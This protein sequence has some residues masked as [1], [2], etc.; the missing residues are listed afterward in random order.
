MSKQDHDLNETSDTSHAIVVLE[1]PEQIN[2]KDDEAIIAMMTG[3]AI[4]DYVYS[5]RQGGKL[6]EGLTLAGINE[7]ANRRGGIV[8]DEMRYEEKE[9][10]WI[11]TVKAMD[12]YTGSSRY[13]AYEQ[14]K[15]VSGR[16]DP[17]AFTKAVH[18]AQR[19]AIKQLLPTAIIRDVLNWYLRGQR[20]MP[21]HIEEEAK[22][23]PADSVS[24]NQKAAFALALKLREPLERLGVTQKGFWD[25]VRRRFHVES[26]NEMREEHWTQ[27]AAELRAASESEAVLKE[28]VK[29][30]EQVDYAAKVAE[31]GVEYAPSEES[32]E[33]ETLMP[34]EILTA[35]EVEAEQAKAAKPE[36][37]PAP[38]KPAP[39]RPV[40]GRPVH[41]AMKRTAPAKAAGKVDP[42][43]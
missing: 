33:S 42:L 29:R 23:E 10:S 20:P 22:P 30:I 36:S 18:K 7:A 24:S 27:L 35:Q 2:A 8:V 34:D 13:G 43:F 39:A 28:F 25:Y 41:G 38:A 14:P 17:F 12:T 1:N 4:S 6:V 31:E 26:R 21:V 37:K 9:N 3:Q 16:E 15:K 11:A 40:A 19:N 5:F 32:D